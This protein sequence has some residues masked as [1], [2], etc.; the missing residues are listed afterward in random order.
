[1]WMLETEGISRPFPFFTH[2]SEDIGSEYL[3]ERDTTL[4]MAILFG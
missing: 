1:M 2:T 3:W 4:A